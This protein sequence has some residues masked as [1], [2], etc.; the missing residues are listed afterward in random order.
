MALIGDKGILRT[1]LVIVVSKQ[2]LRDGDE[3]ILWTIMLLI[4]CLQNSSPSVV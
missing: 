1:T 3:C 4:V 2:G